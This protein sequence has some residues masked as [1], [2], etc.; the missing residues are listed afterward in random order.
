MFAPLVLAVVSAI[1]LV[2][3]E[4]NAEREAVS[5]SPRLA[6]LIVVDQMRPDYLTRFAPLFKGGLHRLL[7]SGAVYLNAYHEHA[8]TE[9]AVGHSAIST[10]CYPAH[11]GIVGN[12]IYDRATERAVYSC[13]DSA[14]TILGHEGLSG[15]SPKWLMAETL[16]DR[17]KEYSTQSKV[18][19]VALKDRAAILMGGH[20]ADGAYWFDT[21]SGDY[22]TSTYYESAIPAWLNE[23]NSRQFA[24]SVLNDNWSC[25]LDTTAYAISG[26]DLESWENDGVHTTFPHKAE[27]VAWT[28]SSPYKGVP[29]SP[30]ADRM[31]IRLAEKIISENSLGQD[32]VADML[33]I[34][35]SAPDYIGHRYGPNS[36]EI[37]DYYLRL[38]GYL[39]GLFMFL[40][41]VVGPGGYV[42]AL[43]SD[44]GVCECP[45]EL[46]E[47]GVDAGRIPW[48]EFTDAMKGAN[49]AVTAELHL[50]G[51][52][53]TLK[54][55]EV[56]VNYDN[57]RDVSVEELQSA[58]AAEIRKIPFVSD[59]F[60]RAELASDTENDRPFE[61]LYRHCL[62]PGR[63]PDL[64]LL[65]NE[66]YFVGD[67]T[68]GTTHVSAYPYD[69]NVPI[70]F[71]GG[72]VGRSTHSE[73]VRTV[74]IAPTLAALLGAGSFDRADGRPLNP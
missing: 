32:G 28:A 62:Y 10:G 67:G 58:I 3:A 70:V 60:T 73:R 50:T 17:L 43:S 53:F 16:G 69:T 52:A 51:P 38:D 13:E 49:E 39:E 59:V 34:G 15:R 11:N 57:A 72:G 48:K 45:E 26:H 14:A 12:E 9:T 56:V 65:L 41:S 7:D 47:K 8:A 20:R 42:V 22:V 24:D 64:F 55:G 6:V 54:S 25:L 19:S 30:F 71:W 1:S 23:F 4:Y 27:G 66:H 40:D 18:F 68:T 5:R 31:T 46:R 61:M 33:C 37:Q 35:C 29:V 2:H 44:H 74:D 36:W 21:K 63:G